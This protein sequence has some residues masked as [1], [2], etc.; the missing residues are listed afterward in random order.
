MSRISTR[1]NTRRSGGPRFAAWGGLGL[2]LALTGCSQ[3]ST[4]EWK[5]LGLPEP[6]SDRAE[7]TADLW[8]GSWTAA[9]IIGA[10]VWGLILWTCFRYRRRHDEELPTQVRYNLPIEVLYTIA[11]IIV[12]AVLF[13]F[14]VEKQNAVQEV[15]DEPDHNV[16]VTAQR[17]SWIFNYQDEDVLGGE[18]DV[19]EAGTPE[20]VPE[21]WLVEDQSVT[22]ELHSPDVI[23]SF[24][25]PA[26]LYKLDVIP[27]RD[28]SF[29]LTPTTAGEFEGRCAELCGFQHSRMLFT[30]KVVDQ[31]IYDAYL[32]DLQL[33]G[34]VGTLRGAS[35][36]EDVTGL[37]TTDEEVAE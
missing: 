14:T 25:V 29:S 4:D 32:R 33:R 35:D 37:E 13:F 36:S 19:Y 2:L 31:E 16:L 15:V 18:T 28:Q 6:A 24:W 23:H 10:F 34:Q 9:L 7:H 3:E 11:P 8:M 27:G 5:R 30:V 17:W 26:F 21:L 20:T 12:V 22:F 1:R